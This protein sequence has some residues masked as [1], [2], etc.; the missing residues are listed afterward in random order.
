MKCQKREKRSIF[1]LFT[2]YTCDGCPKLK[3]DEFI[4]IGYHNINIYNI[5]NGCDE[6]KICDELIIFNNKLKMLLYEFCKH[7]DNNI[8][9]W[10]DKLNPL[11]EY[12]Q[13]FT[14]FIDLDYNIHIIKF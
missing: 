3:V 7:Q 14:S 8:L 10:L 6:T 13:I 11:E 4:Q 1:S 9:L 2:K 12:D 5:S